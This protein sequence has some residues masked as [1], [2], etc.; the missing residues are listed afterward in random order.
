M[1]TFRLRNFGPIENV[2]VEFGD[3]TFFVGPQA[4]GK[5]LFLELL[6]YIID[7]EYVLKQLRDYNYILDK[8]KSSNY[9][10]HILRQWDEPD[11]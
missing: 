10:R 6:K 4:S 3:L 9:S 11:I 8:K 5:S 2:N 7:K 1:N